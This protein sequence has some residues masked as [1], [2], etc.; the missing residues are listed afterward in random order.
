MIS[1]EKACM[2][3]FR[4][5]VAI[6]WI[7]LF[8]PRTMMAIQEHSKDYI[9]E[10][11]TTEEIGDVHEIWRPGVRLAGRGSGDH[12]VYNSNTDFPH[13]YVWS[14]WENEIGFGG[15][16]VITLNFY[17]IEKAEESIDMAEIGDRIEDVVS[18]GGLPILILYGMPDSISSCP[19]YEEECTGRPAYPP[20]DYDAWEEMVYDAIT[21]LSAEGAFVTNPILRLDGEPSRGL[22]G[23]YYHVWNEPNTNGIELGGQPGE[24]GGPTGFW[25]GTREDFHQLYLSAVRAVERAEIDF[26][27]DLAIGGCDFQRVEEFLDQVQ[28]NDPENWIVDFVQFCSQNGL[29]LDFF[30]WNRSSNNPDF[31]DD[32]RVS[33]TWREMLDG[34]GYGATELIL[35]DVS[36][37]IYVV[38]E[39]CI[40]NTISVERDTEILASLIPA[41]FYK[42]VQVGMVE[43]I[44]LEAVQNY[45]NEDEN[46]D[47]GLFRGGTGQ[48]FTLSNVMKPAYNTFLMLTRLRDKR[49]R[50]A[51]N[52]VG[53]INESQDPDILVSEFIDCMATVDSQTGDLAILVW[54]YF[55]PDRFRGG[56]GQDLRYE[57]LNDVLP[58]PKDTRIMINN[59]D[60]KDRYLMHRY[61]LD[62]A[63]SN[64]WYNREE[65]YDALYNNGGKADEINNWP[66]VKLQ[67]VEFREFTENSS[68]EIPLLLRP[69]SVHLI[70]LEKVVDDNTS[71]GNEGS[72]LGD[73]LWETVIQSIN[74]PNPF[75]ETTTI[76]FQVSV[77]EVNENEFDQTI[78]EDDS[79]LVS[80]EN[81]RIPIAIHVFDIRGRL[82]RSLFD[83][84]VEVGSDHFIRWE[85]R[86]DRG[87]KVALGPYFYRIRSPNRVYIKKMI[88]TG[89]Q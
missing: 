60:S 16:Y 20:S 43:R 18:Q 27:L 52:H 80:E 10:V 41:L 56:A 86:N 8:L 74:Y 28:E 47:Y 66:E 61:K 55:N 7:L 75:D 30:T 78:T 34:Y 54:F 69:Y 71:G 68:I 88:Y 14:K 17:D 3:G 40:G 24:F 83:E 35:V 87:E 32:H 36:S 38:A 2:I 1:T 77:V 26:D 12:P 63:T 23:I 81:D 25:R 73:G 89:R 37:H 5:F 29:R 21:Y 45:N 42:E 65:I 67:E 19:L 79:S 58:E 50:V 51:K 33:Q 72:G 11:Y 53:I 9:F 57:V 85:A 22:E 4:F 64:S 46:H 76:S 84:E 15:T 70:Y 48:M 31:N 62:A 6:L 13:P 82:V 39:N 49:L 59:V 44:V